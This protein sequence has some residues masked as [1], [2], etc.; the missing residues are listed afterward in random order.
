MIATSL[1]IH[2]IESRKERLKGRIK[3]IKWTIDFAT[4]ELV[5]FGRI[6]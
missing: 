6:G 4:S 3:R 5:R 1:M 2:E